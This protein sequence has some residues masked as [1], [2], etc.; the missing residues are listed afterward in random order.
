MR[1][2]YEAAAVRVD[3]GVTLATIDFLSRIVAFT[4]W[5]S[6]IAAEGLA[7]RPTRSRSAITRAWLIFSNTPLSRHAANHR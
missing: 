1:L 4:L 7:S 5:L 2:E 3:E 6:M